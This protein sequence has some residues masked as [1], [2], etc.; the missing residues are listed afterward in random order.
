[1]T[2]W[3]RNVLINKRLTATLPNFYIDLQ[4]PTTHVVLNINFQESLKLLLW[5]WS[6]NDEVL[7]FQHRKVGGK[8]V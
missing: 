1:M 5:D 7:R 3:S 4:L 2:V 6:L 8:H